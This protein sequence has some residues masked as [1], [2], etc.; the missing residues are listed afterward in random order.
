MDFM[1]PTRMQLLQVM[2]VGQQTEIITTDEVVSTPAPLMTH[3][4]MNPRRE[5]RDGNR[6]PFP[7]TSSATSAQKGSLLP[8]DWQIIIEYIQVSGHIH[9]QSVIVVSKQ[10]VHSTNTKHS[11]PRTH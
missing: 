2:S 7:V 5:G 3:L 8:V 11:I 6:G 1:L 10:G 9:A 4:V